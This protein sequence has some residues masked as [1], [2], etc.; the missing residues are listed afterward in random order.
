MSPHGLAAV[1]NPGRWKTARHL[2]VLNEYLLLVAGGHIERLAVF[3]PPRHGKSTMVSHHFPAWWLMRFP[4]ER[5]IEAG[6]GNQFAASW[7][8]KSRQAIEYAFQAGISPVQVDPSKS[9]AEEWDILGHHGGLYAVGIGGGVTGRGADLL[10]IDDPVKSREVAESPTFRNKTWDWYRD[11]VYTRLHPGGKIVLVQTRWHHDDLAGRILMNDLYEQDWTILSMP[12]LAEPEV[13]DALGRQPGEALWPER[14]SAEVMENRQKILGIYSFNALYQQRPSAR[15]GML[16]KRDWFNVLEAVPADL[17]V[18]RAWDLAATENDGDWTVGVLMGAKDNVFYVLDVTAQRYGPAG[19]RR[20]L[21]AT[22]EQDGK[23]VRIDLPQDPG[24]AGKDQVRE[25]RGLLSGFSV[26]SSPESGS[27]TMRAE[28]VAAQAEVGNV[29][30]LRGPWNE[31]FLDEMAN[32]NP[33][34]K[35]QQD[36]VVDATSRAFAMLSRA[37]LRYTPV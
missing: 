23:M 27:K 33:D 16:F 37:T 5:V 2:T 18:V 28:G 6:Y 29:K 24:Q 14:Y 32:F 31:R 25:F 3:M 9:A 21:R 19:V 15:E 36:D 1:L 12:A 22:A 13:E 34:V 8:R 7:G 20:L 4:D 35:D 17:N 30:L 10:I 11:D 26:R